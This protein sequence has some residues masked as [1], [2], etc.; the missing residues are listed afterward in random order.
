MLLISHH[1]IILEHD[2]KLNIKNKI[3]ENYISGG[4]QPFLIRTSPMSK[5]FILMF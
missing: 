4:E 3:N 2:I 1:G 5:L